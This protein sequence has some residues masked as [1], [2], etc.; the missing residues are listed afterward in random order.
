VDGKRLS[1]LDMTIIMRQHQPPTFEHYKKAAKK[2]VFVHYNSAL[3]EA[4][5]MNIIRNER[6][7]ISE[8]CTTTTTR[9]RH[10]KQFDN[11]L[12]SNGYPKSFID[13]SYKCKRQSIG[14]PQNEFRIPFVGDEFSRKLKSIFHAEG[15]KVR[16]YH[17]NKSLRS[18]LAKKPNHQSCTSVTCKFRNSGLCSRHHVVYEVSCNTCRSSYIGSTVRTL[19]IRLA[20]HLRDMNSSIHKH[21]QNCIDENQEGIHTKLR[22]KILATENDIINLRIKEAILIKQR[23][24][25][26]NSREEMREIQLLL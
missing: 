9:V 24:P 25:Q 7:R 11:L 13:K 16:F 23:H 21:L 26:M 6:S 3:P 1:L 2:D 14:S 17:S 10:N 12:V 22:V 4:M 15:L 20:E 5:K 8:R 18:L 19:H